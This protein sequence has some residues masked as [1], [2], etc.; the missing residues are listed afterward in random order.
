VVPQSRNILAAQPAGI[1]S[2][3]PGLWP[4]DVAR[5]YDIPLG[6]DG[7]EQ[8]VGVI[9]LGGGYLQSDVDVA[10]SA[11]KLP[12]NKIIDL[13]INNFINTFG[14]SETADTEVSMDVQI[15]ASLLPKAR[16]V[17]YSAANTHADFIAAVNT[18]A[19]DTVYRPEVLSIS[20][21]IIETFWSPA[22]I[23]AMQSA[24]QDAKKNN[25]TVV[26][27]SG[28]NL[29]Y[30]GI[31]IPGGNVLFPG[32]SPDVLCCGGTEVVLSADGSRI[33]QERVWNDQDGTTGTGG[34]ISKHFVVPSYQSSL[35]LPPGIDDNH[36][37]RGVP[38]VAALAS[39]HPGYRI[40]L[41]NVAK[42]KGGTS[43][44]TPLWAALIT[45][46]N[47]KRGARLGFVNPCVYKNPLCQPI[48][49]GNNRSQQGGYDAG[50]GWSACTGLG[51]PKGAATITG[52]ATLT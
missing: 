41:N 18:A 32:S 7:H 3:G 11:Q 12:P 51:V 42:A 50:D 2:D 37:G 30:C 34:G 6:A 48:A 29:A 36:T 39:E 10:L 52:L 4:R 28:D 1:D 35:H 16:I 5:L 45:L 40:L 22:E 44:A 23:D 19:N 13:S 43:A 24:L 15:L 21:G 20:F 9:S 33:A 27:A 25:I 46:A 38:D 8:C 31:P 49:T 47:A 14:T 17:V 26:A